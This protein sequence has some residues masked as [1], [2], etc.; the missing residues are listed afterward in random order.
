MMR[1]CWWWW[2]W[3]SGRISGLTGYYW[4]YVA[5]RM[6]QCDA[7]VIYWVIPSTRMEE[8]GN[9]IYTVKTRESELVFVALQCVKLRHLKELYPMAGIKRYRPKNLTPGKRDKKLELDKK[10][11]KTFFDGNLPAWGFKGFLKWFVAA[12]WPV[13][14][15]DII[16]VTILTPD[17][18]G[19]FLCKIEF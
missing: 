8:R 6:K 15:G 13:G 2:Y 19:V 1:Q 4:Y 16:N 14:R 9:K 7:N 10:T 18:T 17:W 12:D 11:M 3:Q 5:M